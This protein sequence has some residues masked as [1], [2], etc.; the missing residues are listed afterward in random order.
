MGRNIQRGDPVIESVSRIHRG[1]RSRLEELVPLTLR[2][3]SSHEACTPEDQASWLRY[4]GVGSWQDAL[5]PS[6]RYSGS[7]LH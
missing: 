2:I 4:C 7:P 3:S 1:R 6:R 5:G